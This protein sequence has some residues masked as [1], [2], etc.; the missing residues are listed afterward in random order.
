MLSANEEP[1]ALC[2]SKHVIKKFGHARIFQMLDAADLYT[3]DASMKT[4]NTILYLAYKHSSTLKFL[5]S[6][7]PIGGLNKEGTSDAVG[8]SISDPV[9]T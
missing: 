8:G 7:D 4:V 1:D 5:V 3:D 6:C 9:E 2:L